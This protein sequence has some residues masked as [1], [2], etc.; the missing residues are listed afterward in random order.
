[1]FPYV[2][3]IHFVGIGGAGMSG[4]A[5]VLLNL[6]YEISGSDI[7]CT[8]VTKRLEKLGARVYYTHRKSNVKNVDV[9][10][11]SSA[12]DK[13]N[14]ELLASK[15][16]RIPVIPRI[17]MLAEL[18][19]M[20]YTIAVAGTHGKT[21]TTLMT[22][23]I[24]SEAGLDPTIIIGGKIK[25][26][27]TGAKLG[28]GELIVAEAD[29]SDGSFLRLTPLVGIITN[30]DNDH[31]D[32][33]G[34]ITNLKKSFIIYTHR[35]AFY[36]CVIAC[37]ESKNVRKILPHIERK[38]LTYGLTKDADFYAKDII[39]DK[40]P[41]EYKC[42]FR[43]RFLGKIKL[44]IPG[45]HNI[46]NSLAAIACGV[47][48]NI[49]F[50]SIKRGLE[51]FAAAERRLQI[52][53]EKDGILVIDDYG[54]HPT[55]IKAT[56]EA[57][58]NLWPTRRLVIIFQPHR[59][60]RTKY[61]YREFAKALSKSDVVKILDIYSAGE[62][63]IPGVTS[64]LIYRELKKVKPATEYVGETNKMDRI[65]D[66][67]KPGDILLTLGAGDV[68]KVGDEFLKR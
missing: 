62:K 67:L 7:R 54:H 66:G 53:G 40:I 65:E 32:F 2:K 8:D 19:R 49:D 29:E 4:L 39:L 56:I 28:K 44:F 18:A 41:V 31:L 60:T 27:N 26:L 52:K 15:E 59:Y 23:Y 46:V 42:Y 24:L 21:T 13:N 10:V 30:I 47:F 51:I 35:V 57:I 17:D 3:K 9:V 36:G 6:G 50:T 33:Y 63:P 55:E 43:K 58:R 64:K 68:W 38:V 5:E 1:M 22:G 48:L 14:I 34:N 16:K 61:L 11:Y 37:I 20:K 45:I 12:V 25:G